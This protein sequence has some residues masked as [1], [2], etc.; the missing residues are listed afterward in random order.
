MVTAPATEES[1][2]VALVAVVVVGAIVLLAVAVTVGIVI[3]RKH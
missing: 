3:V 1:V 2:D